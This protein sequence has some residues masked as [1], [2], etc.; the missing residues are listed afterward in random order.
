MAELS[1][2]SS[3]LCSGARR[4]PLVLVLVSANYVL[5][6]TAK[7]QALLHDSF[8]ASVLTCTMDPVRYLQ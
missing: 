6:I 1:F 7:Y 4:L 3:A 5:S 8:T 2:P